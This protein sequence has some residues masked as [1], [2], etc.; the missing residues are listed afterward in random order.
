MN[1]A[2]WHQELEKQGKK[3]VYGLNTIVPIDTPTESMNDLKRIKRRMK[4]R[5][6]KKQMA[7]KQRR[8]SEK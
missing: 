2:R 6:S 3:Y 1:D 4:K 5:L 8:E 7:E